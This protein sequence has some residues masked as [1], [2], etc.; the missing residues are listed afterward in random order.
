MPAPMLGLVPVTIA[1]LSA[2]FT[3]RTIIPGT[4]RVNRGLPPTRSA[5]PSIPRRLVLVATLVVILGGCQ[6]GGRH[7][8]TPS[9]AL[10]DMVRGY[11]RDVTP[12][13][14]FTASEQGLR[15]Y[16]RVLAND[17]GEKYRSGMLAICSRY[18]DGLRRLDAA[19]LGDVERVTYDALVFRVTSCVD[20]YRFP[21]HLL[22]VNQ[23]GFTWP[24]RFPIVGAGRGQH[25]FK[26]ARNYEDFLGRIDGFVTWMDT[27]IANMREG[28]AA[29]RRAD[30]GRPRG[31][32]VLR[33]ATALPG[34]D[35]RRDTPPLDH[36]V[37]GRDPAQDRAGLPAAAH[38]HRDRVPAGLPRHRWLRRAA[39]RARVV[40]PGGAER[41]HHHAHAGGDSRHRPRRG[42][43]PAR[44]DER[45]ACGD[46]HGRRAGAPALSHAGDAAA[47]LRRPARRRGRGAAEA[48][49]PAAEGG[50]RGPPDRAVPRALDAVELRGAL[51]RRRATGRLLS[52]R[53][54]RARRRH[55][56]RFARALPAR[57][58]ARPSP[59][60]GA[61]A[62]EHRAAGLPALRLVRGLRRGLGPLRRR[63]RRGA[64]RLSEPLGSAGHAGCR[65]VPG[66]TPRRGH[67]APR[68]GLDARAGDR[69]PGRPDARHR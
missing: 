33:A 9:S 50:L 35:R 26:T 63:P 8:A 64:G 58:R 40:R 21:W 69:L 13:Y 68:Q 2:S 49:R 20:G 32:R 28:A 12:Y 52:Q 4:E 62:R 56:G 30:R 7:A 6:S 23:G 18:R 34:V 1:T 59:A 24:S 61:A 15:D 36:A 14:P 53:G 45:P 54:R 57:G 60:D 48:V 41:H 22:P 17:I 55:R 25:P 39:G 16:D 10:S 3:Q 66:L 43:A 67:R 31:E 5:M 38:L 65:A 27:A 37:R 29:A 47:G 46:R 44:R 11:D 42:R 19:T 51:T